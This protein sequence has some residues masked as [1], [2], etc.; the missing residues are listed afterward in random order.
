MKKSIII[1]IC[2]LLCTSAFARATTPPWLFFKHVPHT[3]GAMTSGIRVQIMQTPLIRQL[4]TTTQPPVSKNLFKPRNIPTQEPATYNQHGQTTKT[5]N[6]TAQ[7]ETTYD[8]YGRI[9]STRTTTKHTFTQTKDYTYDSYGR[10][11]SHVETTWDTSAPNTTHITTHYFTYNSLGQVENEVI[12]EK[13][14][15][16]ITDLTTLK[17]KLA[18]MTAQEYN[19]FFNSLPPNI[20][21]L[22]L[23]A[24]HTTTPRQAPLFLRNNTRQR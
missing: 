2:L 15:G 6:G 11:I 4:N 22:V 5:N 9:K 13:E 14:T 8:Q 19:T 3:T 7:T 20:K 12:I 16:I 23:N 1:L 21:K 17:Q 18:T 10:E 24:T